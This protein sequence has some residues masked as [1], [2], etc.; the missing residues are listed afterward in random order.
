MLGRGSKEVETEKQKC[1]CYEKQSEAQEGIDSEGIPSV[2]NKGEIN[3]GSQ[4][5]M[6][7]L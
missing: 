4:T 1:W 7:L 3:K 5:R 2:T 6:F